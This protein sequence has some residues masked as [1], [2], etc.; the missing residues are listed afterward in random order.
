MEADLHKND[1]GKCG[2]KVLHITTIDTGGAYKGA[3]R[4]HES[5]QMQGVDSQIMVRTRLYPDS[6]VL[7]AFHNPIGALISKGKNGINKLFA[8]GEIASDRLG[9]DLSEREAVL[10]ADII[11]LHWVNSFLSLKEIE[12]LAKSGK[13]IVWVMHDMWLFT[14][15]CHVDKYC[16]RY[17]EQCGLCPYL[18]AKQKDDLSHR[19]FLAKVRTIGKTNITV[20]GPSRWIVEQAGKSEILAGKKI[21]YMPNVL[22]TDLYCPIE[23]RESL[24]GKYDIPKDKKVIL[25]GAADN[26]TENDNK[27]FRYLREAVTCLPADQYLLLIFGNAGENLGLPK[28]L[29]VIKTGYVESERKLIDLYRIAD[30]L[31]NP[32]NQE[33]FGYTVCE[34]MACGTPAVGFPIGGI[35]EQIGHK[36]NGYLAAYRDAGDLAKGIEYCIENRQKLG[37]NARETA[38]QYSYE[39]A[40]FREIL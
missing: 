8:R 6:P 16:G 20:A 25:F 9:T 22:N 5:M 39:K 38:L 18:G 35:R 2:L 3:L 1:V 33:S 21:L 40:W 30:V 26:G 36:A 4:L 7:E 37:R 24:R 31:V 28:E 13:R 14:G 12:K 19:N 11:V 27:G 29:E 17:C 32:S 15:G 34:A 23:D 10:R